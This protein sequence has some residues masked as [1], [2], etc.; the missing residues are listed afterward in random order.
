MKRK[1][2]IARIGVG[3]VYLTEG[4]DTE[5]YCPIMLDGDKEYQRVIIVDTGT[6]ELWSMS[7]PGD[8]VEFDVDEKRDLLSSPT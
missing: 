6:L 2:I 4:S 1:G 7:K 8:E 3:K 5:N